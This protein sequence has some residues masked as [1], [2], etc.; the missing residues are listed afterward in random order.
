MAGIFLCL[1]SG[2][3]L[4][5]TTAFLA[6]ITN[7]PEENCSY[8]WQP[9]LYGCKQFQPRVLLFRQAAC[10]LLCF[11]SNPLPRLP[12]AGTADDTHAATIPLAP[13]LWAEWHRAPECPC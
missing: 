12:T 1:V 9:R 10:T 3:T 6:F 13:S 5:K 4:R 2:T 11:Q 7:P 8:V